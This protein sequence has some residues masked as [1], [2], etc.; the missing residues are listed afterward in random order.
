MKNSS[1]AFGIR[2]LDS[3]ENTGRAKQ[4]WPTAVPEKIF[5]IPDTNTN[6]ALRCV[7]QTKGIKDDCTLLRLAGIDLR[8]QSRRLWRRW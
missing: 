6:A 2:V 1:A 7:Q 3:C 5:T 8:V 4:L